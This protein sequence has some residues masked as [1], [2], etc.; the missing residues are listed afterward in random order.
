MKVEEL[1]AML[2]AE[3]KPAKYR[4]RKV[5]AFGLKFD[6]KAEAAR[7][8]ELLMLERLERIGSLRRQV[9]LELLE[10]VKL[11]GHTRAQPAVRLIVD[12]AYIEGG[13]WVYEDMKS[14]A[15]AKLPAFRLKCHM[16]KAIHGI[17]V[18]VV[19]G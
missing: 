13:V 12:F 6:S 11:W 9:S 4:N 2:A 19:Y 15:T 7:W 17:D 18:R 3:K 14:P 1:R 8:G 10:G 16:A 5:E